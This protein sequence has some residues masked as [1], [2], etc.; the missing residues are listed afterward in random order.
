MHYAVMFFVMALIAALF[1][2][3]DIAPVIAGVCKVAFFIFV[4]LGLWFMV[5][6]LPWR[7][8]DR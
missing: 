6:Y 8:D 4:T 7:S 3:T 2:F 1:G 5:W